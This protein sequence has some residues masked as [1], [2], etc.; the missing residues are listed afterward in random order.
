[1][2]PFS[3]PVSLSLILLWT[4]E[5]GEL[6]NKSIAAAA[7]LPMGTVVDKDGAVLDPSAGD[8]DPTQAYGVHMQYGQVYWANS[9]FNDQYVIWPSDITPADKQAAIDHLEKTFLIIK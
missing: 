4:H 6:S 8:W 9:V 3:K 1:M 2:D 5:R 7:P